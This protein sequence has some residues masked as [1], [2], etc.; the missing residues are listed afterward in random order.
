MKIGRECPNTSPL[1]CS[2]PGSPKNGR[3]SVEFSSVA[4]SPSDALGVMEQRALL[5]SSIT[6]WLTGITRSFAQ[7][8]PSLFVPSMFSDTTP[9]IRRPK[10]WKS[11][12]RFHLSI[13]VVQANKTKPCT[14]QL[15]MR[16][17]I[18]ARNHRVPIFWQLTILR[19]SK[20]SP[21]LPQFFSRACPA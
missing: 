16:W 3:Y 19:D 8:P 13:R 12:L 5:D 17:G 14:S 15:L 9:G 20:L 7:N 2:L 6:S 4:T 10:S 18:D 11:H 21:A 1:S